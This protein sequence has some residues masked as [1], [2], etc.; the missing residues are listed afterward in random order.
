MKVQG[1]EAHPDEVEWQDAA[2][3][4]ERMY[5]DYTTLKELPA[6]GEM[7]QEP[8]ASVSTAMLVY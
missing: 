3:A 5:N 1:V 4:L 7:L 2:D 6:A 8:S